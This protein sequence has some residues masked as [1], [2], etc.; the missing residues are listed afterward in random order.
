MQ[1]AIASGKGGAGK[2][3]L[4]INL[5]LSYANPVELL[6]CDVEEPNIH[7]FFDKASLSSSIDSSVYIPKLNPEKCRGCGLCA[8]FCRFSA[9]TISTPMFYYDLCHGCGGCEYVCPKGAISE[10]SR[11]IGKV[12][13]KQF[14]QLRLLSGHLNLGERMAVPLIKDVKKQLGSS[15]L[16]LIDAPPGSSCPMVTAVG[17][18]N[19]IVLVAEPTPF[20]LSDLKLVVETAQ[21]LGI[22]FGIIVNRYGV[23]NDCIHAFCAKAR[24][25]LLGVVPNDKRI[26][27]LYSMGK[28]VVN[29]IKKYKILFQNL[30]DSIIDCASANHNH[31]GLDENQ[32]VYP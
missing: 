1:I 2:T 14:N 9:I 17:G 20:G 25:P 21:Q 30:L 18:A 6:D 23:G 8:K 32:R 4:A 13:D 3:T 27:E 7:L 19:F 26:A 29:E 11:I 12:K 5:A 15:K 10:D 24:I 28:P 16:V 31:M 22:P